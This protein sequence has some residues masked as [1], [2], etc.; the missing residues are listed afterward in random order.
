MARTSNATKTERAAD[1]ATADK[2]TAI[3]SLVSINI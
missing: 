3:H 1:S 2:G